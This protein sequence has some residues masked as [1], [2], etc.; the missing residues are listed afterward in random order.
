VG[1]V[2]HDRLLVSLAQPRRRG[3]LTRLT[4][5]PGSRIAITGASGYIGR[6]LSGY[7]DS[8]GH[9]VIGIGRRASSDI[10]WDPESGRL[11]AGALEGVDAVVNLAGATIA[12][13][14]TTSARREIMESRVKAT[15]L[16]ARTL[17]ALARRPRALISMSGVNYY[18]DGGDERIDE[19][20]SPGTGFLASVTQAWEASADPARAAGIRVTH[21]RLAPIIGPKGGMLSKLLPLFR[22][23]VGGRGGRGR[24]WF[25]WISM[26]D[27]LAGMYHLLSDDSLG[28]AVNL[29]SP[30]PV[31]NAEFTKALARAV[32][33]PAFAVAPAFA[34]RLVLG[35]F[36]E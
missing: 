8:E 22:L 7:L 23:G 13:R 21:P 36:G 33:R 30:E 6:A 18:G 4:L 11:D 9:R 20:A 26:D 5:A 28:G 24:Q 3:R 17:A 1:A 29:A 27:A 32:H 19:T 35:D 31:T 2:S 15:T 12:Q 34:V 10:R 14:W 16:L 25:S